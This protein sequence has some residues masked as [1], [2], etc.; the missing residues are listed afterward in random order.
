MLHFTLIATRYREDTLPETN[1][2]AKAATRY[3]RPRNI[4]EHNGT[5]AD[6]FASI[7]ASDTRYLGI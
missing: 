7:T 1:D 3:L 4:K 5:C 2:N 6:P